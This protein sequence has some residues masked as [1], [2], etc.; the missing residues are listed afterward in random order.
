MVGVILPITEVLCYVE[1]VDS[2]KICLDGNAQ[3]DVIEEFNYILL[4][5]LCHTVFIQLNA[6]A[7]NNF[8]N[9]FGAGFISFDK[10]RYR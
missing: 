5:A 7:F 10:Y 1:E 3:A 2:F 8:R 6:A 9:Y 4:G